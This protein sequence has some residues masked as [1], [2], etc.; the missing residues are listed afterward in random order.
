M[1]PLP[2]GLSVPSDWELLKEKTLR[3]VDRLPSPSFLAV[4]R[5][6]SGLITAPV[7][8]HTVTG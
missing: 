7:S 5:V 1:S 2:G 3:A 4:E 8:L 6:R